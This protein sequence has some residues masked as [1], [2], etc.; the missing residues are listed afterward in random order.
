MLDGVAKNA[1]PRHTGREP[2]IMTWWELLLAAAAF[3]VGMHLL[4]FL[5]DC[6]YHDDFHIPDSSSD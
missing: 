6:W 5:F 3:P 1:T 2:R 4:W